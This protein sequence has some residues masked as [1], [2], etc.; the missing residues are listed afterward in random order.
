MHFHR[1]YSAERF[2]DR[3]RENF[4]AAAAAAGETL[5]TPGV[6]LFATIP[7]APGVLELSRLASGTAW[8]FEPTDEALSF[9][10]RRDDG[11]RLIV[12]EGRQIVTHEKLEV[13]ILACRSEIE[14]GLP[15]DDTLDRALGGGGLT[16]LPWGFGKWTFGRRRLVDAALERHAGPR[17]FLGDNGGRPRLSSTPEAFR[18]ARALGVRVLPGSDPLPLP[19]HADRAG[20]F[21]LRLRGELESERPAAS[22]CERLADPATQLDAFGNGV[23]LWRFLRDQFSLRAVAGPGAAA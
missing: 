17:F 21:G 10:A 7:G 1:G 12:V 22:L 9:R 15:L 5:S 23:P 16:V 6:L 18:R 11:A 2:L 13:L 8:R 14:P 3:A 20:S 4:S 19:H